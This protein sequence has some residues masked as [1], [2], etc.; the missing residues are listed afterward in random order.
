MARNPCPGLKVLVG[1]QTTLWSTQPPLGALPSFS[2]LLS[3]WE[4][5]CGLVNISSG[6][7]RASPETEQSV[8]PGHR[9]TFP[10]DGPTEFHAGEGGKLS[11]TS[12][13]L[14]ACSPDE[15]SHC[16]GEK[17]DSWEGPWS[18]KVVLGNAL[19][20]QPPETSC[21]GQDSFALHLKHQV[22]EGRQGLFLTPSS[23]EEELW[24]PAGVHP[25]NGSLHCGHEAGVQCQSL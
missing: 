9:P 4:S 3:C 1:P 24:M 23:I 19:I 14:A 12:A 21:V 17:G 18:Q 7:T 22:P 20:F 11:P 15:P 10:L 6:N 5:Q 13:P 2:T 25:G 16:A 8:T